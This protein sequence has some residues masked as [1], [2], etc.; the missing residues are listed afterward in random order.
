M[1]DR[2]RQKE[3]KAHRVAKVAIAAKKKSDQLQR[4]ILAARKHEHTVVERS[5][6]GFNTLTLAQLRLQVQYWQHK[7]RHVWQGLASERW[8]VLLGRTKKSFKMGASPPMRATEAHELE[9]QRYI[10]LLSSVVFHHK[11]V[12]TTEMRSALE[13]VCVAPKVTWE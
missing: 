7:A 5:V 12:M 11:A 10:S 13:G 1:F 3:V 6:E 4:I 9:R 8:R 2:Q